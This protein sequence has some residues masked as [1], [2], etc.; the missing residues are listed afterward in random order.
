MKK[1]KTFKIATQSK[2]ASNVLQAIEGILGHPLQS[3]SFDLSLKC[4]N[5][6]DI[7]VTFIGVSRIPQVLQTAV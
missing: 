5:F 2:F 4:Q 1:K 7:S 3:L 6:S